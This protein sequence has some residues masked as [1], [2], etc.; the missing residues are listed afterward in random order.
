MQVIATESSLEQTTYPL[1]AVEW[2]FGE[3]YT[4]II[5]I[6]EQFLESVRLLK[7]ISIHKGSSSCPSNLKHI[8][9]DSIFWPTKLVLEG[10]R[11][12][13]NCNSGLAYDLATS[14]RSNINSYFDALVNST[15]ANW[16][17]IGAGKES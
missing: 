16:N 6:D 10:R 4:K 5:K 12:K 17:P 11:T 9:D 2:A 1:M 14:A 3:L 7:I 8:V 13:F 15:A